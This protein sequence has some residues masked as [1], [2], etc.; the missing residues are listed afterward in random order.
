MRLAVKIENLGD[1]QTGLLHL[2]HPSFFSVAHL[3]DAA[4]AQLLYYFAIVTDRF[5]SLNA[6]QKRR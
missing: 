1:S 3:S 4:A 6:L 5:S 2:S